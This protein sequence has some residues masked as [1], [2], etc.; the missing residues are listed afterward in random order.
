MISRAEKMRVLMLNSVGYEAGGAELVVRLMRDELQARGHE[1]LVVST[2]HMLGSQKPFAD[3]I[4][5]RRTARGRFWYMHGYQ[6]IKSIVDEFMPDVIHLHTIGEFGAAALWATG[7]VPTLLT[8]HGPEPYSRKLLYWML[9]GNYFR[10]N[11]YRLRDIRPRGLVYYAY[12]LCLQRPLYRRGFRHVDLFVAPSVSMAKALAV[13]VGD[14]PIVQVYNGLPSIRVSP[15]QKSSNVLFVGRL[16]AGK[17]VDVLLRATALVAPQIDG[18]SVTIAG[19][20]SERAQL[21]RVAAAL[22]I[23]GIV[24]FRGW[25]NRAEII[26]C[27]DRAEVV[28]IPSRYAEA[29]GNV[30]VD[31]LAAGRPAVASAAGGLPEV[32]LDRVTGRL[33]P[34]CDP[35]KLADALIDILANSETAERM[36]AASLKHAAKF[37]LS[38]FIDRIE[39]LYR[40]LASKVGESA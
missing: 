15:L 25:L 36:S 35:Q 1:V 34:P 14:V 6:R 8:V 2:D 12:L 18:L 37:E 19:D 9:P 29:L 11:T 40:A 16:E 26:A 28:A 30:A 4:I 24:H 5:P 13:D 20:G 38:V 7:T 27:Y 17:G 22:G 21:E 10:G 23:K 3:V 33:V 39:S 32:V 31:A